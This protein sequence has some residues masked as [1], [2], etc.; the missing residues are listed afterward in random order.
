MNYSW[1]CSSV[2]GHPQ[3][4]AHVHLR[5]RDGQLIPVGKVGKG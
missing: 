2:K 4:V 5:N 3:N 1:M